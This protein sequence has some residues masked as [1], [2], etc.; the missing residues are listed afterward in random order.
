MIVEAV[1]P[2]RIDFA[3]GTL[4]IFP[5][6]VHEGFAVTINAAIDIFTKV[7]IKT[8]DD[9]KILIDSKDS[10]LKIEIPSF[11]NISFDGRLDLLKNVIKNFSIN[12]GL[13][14][15][16][17]SDSPQGAGLAAS[18]SLVVALT[19]ALN[20][21]ENKFSK[22]ELLDLGLHSELQMIRYVGGKPSQDYFAAIEGGFNAIWYKPEGVKVERLKL[23]ENFKKELNERLVLVYVGKSHFSSET[24]W[25]MF[26]NYI[27]R[28]KETVEC[29][30]KIKETALKM[31]DAFVKED[32]EKIGELLEEEMS[33]RKQLAEGVET[34]EAA[35]IIKSAK[36]NG[37]LS[38]KVC[39]AGAGGCI[40]IFCRENKKENVKEAVEKAGGKILPF[41]FSEKGVETK[42]LNL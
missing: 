9:K 25:Q 35:K 26:K 33:N 38:A 40:V 28:K 22:N 36:E 19:F 17:N 1:A 4:D 18:S 39:G 30:K 7:K 3:G 37:A 27:E 13:E 11:E 34:Q 16:T 29:M 14:L 20:Q 42:V 24:N 5:I 2:T 10:N 32:L 8:R 23:G 6:Y 21:I 12:K 31:R 15:E 41:N